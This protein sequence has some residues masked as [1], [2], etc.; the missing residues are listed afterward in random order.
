MKSLL[1]SVNAEPNGHLL[2]QV[3]ENQFTRRNAVQSEATFQG[4]THLGRDERAA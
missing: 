1:F 3:R 2:L 4:V